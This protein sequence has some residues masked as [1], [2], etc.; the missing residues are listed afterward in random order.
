MTDTIKAI[1]LWQPWA[2]LWV[3]KNK[4]HE[5]RHWQ[6]RHRGKLLVH[7]SKRRVDDLDDELCGVLVDEYGKNWLG[8]LRFG[9]IVGMVD[10]LDVIPTERIV[11]GFR[12]TDEERID[13]LCGNF[14][15]GRF[16][17][18]RGTYWVF[19][20]PVPYRGHQTLFDVPREAV[21]EQIA[22]ATEVIGG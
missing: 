22:A 20:Q 1:S 11:N 13:N 12:W 19:P 16:G 10:L 15:D 17:W 8:A 7:A 9:A 18:R 5:T 2:S 6:T 14:D 21:A 4:R 3:S